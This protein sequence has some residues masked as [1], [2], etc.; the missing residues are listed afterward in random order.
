MDPSYG[1]LGTQ[2]IQH[3]V[4]SIE[5]RVKKGS[6]ISYDWKSYGMPRL[7]IRPEKPVILKIN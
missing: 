5:D 7:S 1:F 6:Q 4:L 3:I 2:G